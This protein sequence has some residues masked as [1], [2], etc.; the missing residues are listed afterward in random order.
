MTMFQTVA[1]LD[2]LVFSNFLTY[3]CQMYFPILINRMSPFPILRL[4]DGH[5]NFYSNFKRNFCL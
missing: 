4:L 3:L 2:G 1:S 5:F